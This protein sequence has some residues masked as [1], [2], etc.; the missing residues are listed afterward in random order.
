[1]NRYT[2]TFATC[3]TYGVQS[4]SVTVD[5]RDIEDART[6]GMAVLFQRDPDL[7]SATLVSHTK[8]LIVCVTALEEFA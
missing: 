8:R 5:A 2:L 3:T 4:R 6:A 1:M 7:L